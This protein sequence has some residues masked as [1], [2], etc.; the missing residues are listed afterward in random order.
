MNL[1]KGLKFTIDLNIFFVWSDT[2]EHN[3]EVD[4]NEAH[5]RFCPLCGYYPWNCCLPLRN[6]WWGHFLFPHE[7]LST[8]LQQV[9]ESF[10]F[11]EVFFG[12]CHY[13]LIRDCIKKNSSEHTVSVV[14]FWASVMCKSLRLILCTRY[15]ALTFLDW[16]DGTVFLGGEDIPV[17]LAQRCP[18][19]GLF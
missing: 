9:L 11:F 5:L 8:F 14:L 7:G 17:S 4:N 15:A 6:E 12:L 19:R 2:D 16:G 10:F 3:W 1:N 18:V 13:F